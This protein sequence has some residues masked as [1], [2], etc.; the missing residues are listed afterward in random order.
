MP[1]EDGYD[2]GELSEVDQQE[3]LYE[4]IGFG[5]QPQDQHAHDLFWDAFYN[6]DLRMGDRLDIMDEL[7]AYLFDEYGIDL[8]AVWDWDDFRSWYEGG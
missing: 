4:T 2:Y 3:F 1:P 6:D 8:E 5:E 7:A